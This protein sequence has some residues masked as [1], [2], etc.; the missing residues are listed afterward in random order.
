MRWS[1]E[2]YQEYLKKR[3]QKLDRP[4]VKKKQKYKNKGTWIDGV[5]FRSQLEAKRYRQLKLLFH[6][7]E[8]AGFILQP[9]FILQEGNGENRAME[10]YV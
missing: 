5:F 8:I 6:A 7:G 9:E 1:E 2:Q 4:K 3:G 10:A